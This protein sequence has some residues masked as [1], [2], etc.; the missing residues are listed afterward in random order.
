MSMAQRNFVGDLEIVQDLN[1]QRREWRAQRIAWLIMAMIISA[2]LLG[3]TGGGGPLNSASVSASDG[4]LQ[5][6][7]HSPARREAATG[8]RITLPADGE[9]DTARIWLSREFVDNLLISEIR[10]EPEQVEVAPDRLIYTFNT[11]AATGE[12]VSVV[13]I[14]QPKHIGISSGRIG[15]LNAASETEA[16]L[17]FQQVIL[18]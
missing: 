6:E 17:D 2:A 3:L 13:F 7:Y 8:L 11:S 12:P 18:P 1:Y 14:F 9:G 5:L 16:S 10:P 15:M 4:L